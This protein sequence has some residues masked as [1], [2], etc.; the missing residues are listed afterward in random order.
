MNDVPPSRDPPEDFDE[1]YRRVS[2]LDPSRPSESVRRTVLNH[3]AQLA[4]ERT[5]RRSAAGRTAAGRRRWRPAIF[6]ALAAAALAGLLVTPHFLAPRA[7]ASRPAASPAVPASSPET[8][9]PAPPPRN[10]AARSLVQTAR[11]LDPGTA[12]RRAAE[13]GDV[14][15]LQALLQGQIDL[16]ARDASGRTALMLAIVHGQARAVDALLAHGADP[17]AADSRGTTPLRAA[18]A[19]RRPDIVAA[20]QRAEAR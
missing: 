9:A 18:M 16:D 13:T 5:A 1:Y 20:L 12:L 17:N 2:R 19:A 14:G 3:A 4:A 7:P 10:A 6:G 11:A 8:P 15:A